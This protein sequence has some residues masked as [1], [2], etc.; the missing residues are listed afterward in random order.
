MN[1]VFI[2]SGIL[3]HLFDYLDKSNTLFSHQ[4]IKEHYD[5]LKENK[6]FISTNFIICE[7]LNNITKSVNKD[8]SPY[9]YEWISDFLKTYITNNLTVYEL[10][11]T[12]FDRSI[13]IYAQTKSFRYSF[14]DTS[15]FAFMEKYGFVTIFTTD[16]K[17]TLYS[18]IKGYKIN[19]VDFIDIFYKLPLPRKTFTDRKS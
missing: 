11:N 14:V 4:F 7:S 2:D 9:S 16:E 3:I 19:R 15:V 12:I 13:E 17:M 1:E 8:N 18:Y 10:D 6:H 5:S